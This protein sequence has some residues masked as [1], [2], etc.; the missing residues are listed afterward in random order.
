MTIMKNLTK[1]FFILILSFSCCSSDKKEQNNISTI[2]LEYYINK[3]EQINLS[4]FSHNIRYILL[5]NTGSPLTFSY[6]D[7]LISDSLILAKDNLNCFLYDL[8]GNLLRKIGSEGRGPGE[9]LLLSNSNFGWSGNIYLKG[10][11]DFIEYSVDGKF[12][13]RYKNILKNN[14]GNV[15]HWLQINDSLFLGCIANSTGHE[16]NRLIIFNKK[17]KVKYAL[18]NYRALNR[19]RPFFSETE[20]YVDLYRFENQI[21]I[22]QIVNDTLFIL[23][24]DFKLQPKYVFDFGKYS[25]QPFLGGNDELMK[26]SLNQMNKI[27]VEK[28]FQIHDYYLLC[29]N[30]HLNFPAKRL[31]PKKVKDD[32]TTYYNTTQALG[33]LNK[34]THEFVFCKPTETDNPLFATG[35]FNDVDGGPRFYPMRMVNDST[36]AMWI[37]V[38][39]FKG[40]IG[41]NDFK[42]CQPLYPRKKLSLID[43]EHR[44]SNNDNAILMLVTF[45]KGI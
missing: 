20:R 33:V 4:Q 38:V 21:F 15:G 35:F 40:H 45:K 18:K 34:K 32:F 14:T 8:N 23:T 30:F 26:F 28:L 39:Q 16:E 19:E 3:W 7:C 12:I 5:K 43:F 6:M 31:T 36:L 24:S 9:Y 25:Y 2:K 41:S 27:W 17:G 42:N 11:Y 29:C 22:K 1:F 13:N 10:S 44:I 37:D